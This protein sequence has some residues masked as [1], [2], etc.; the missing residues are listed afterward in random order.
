M[1]IKVYIANGEGELLEETTVEALLPRAF[2]ADD[3]A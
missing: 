1:D 3:L 2:G